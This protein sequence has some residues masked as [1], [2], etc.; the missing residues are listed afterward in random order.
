[1]PFEEIVGFFKFF[2]FYLGFPLFLTAGKERKFCSRVFNFFQ[3]FPFCPFF[4]LFW[5]NPTLLVPLGFYHYQNL[6][7]EIQCIFRMVYLP[8]SP[9]ATASDHTLCICHSGCK[10]LL[11]FTGLVNST[12]IISLSHL[13]LTPMRQLAL[14]TFS[15]AIISC[16]RTLHLSQV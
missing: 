11:C 12:V 9:S 4:L 14:H 10:T 16:L 7:S 2:P 8:G 1:M 13:K 15:S 6:P 5:K 3:L